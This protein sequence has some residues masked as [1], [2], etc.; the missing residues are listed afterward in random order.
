MIGKVVAQTATDYAAWLSGKETADRPPQL[1]GEQLFTELQCASCHRSGAEPARCP[2][3]GGLFG[4]RVQL[5][6]G[7]QVTADEAY[8]RESILRPA[9]KVVAGFEAVMPPYENRL[10]EEEVLQLIAYIKSL[11]AT[12]GGPKL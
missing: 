12:G 3:L 1:T 2:Q 6:G 9:A 8:I 7:Q 4:Q 11:N 10:S 5:A